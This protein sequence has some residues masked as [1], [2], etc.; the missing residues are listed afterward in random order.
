MITKEEF[1]KAL[2]IVSEY[3]KQIEQEI[4]AIIEATQFFDQKEQHLFWQ[5][6]TPGQII[7]FDRFGYAPRKWPER[8][9][10]FTVVQLDIRRMNGTTDVV[11]YILH[12]TDGKKKIRVTG[13]YFPP[14][15]SENMN[16]ND[17]NDK[18][19]SDFIFLTD[20]K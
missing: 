10:I 9:H 14:F 11:E 20:S 1:N 8:G 6:L 19:R 12:I 18:F 5:N 4:A 17:I 13:A 15:D 16:F 2:A 3:K 7:V